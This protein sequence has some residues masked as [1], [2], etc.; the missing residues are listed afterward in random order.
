MNEFLIA[1]VFVSCY[2]LFIYSSIVFIGNLLAMIF[3]VDEANEQFHRFLTIDDF[4]E[5][6]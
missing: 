3:E 1:F 6:E 2:M 5:H 4:W